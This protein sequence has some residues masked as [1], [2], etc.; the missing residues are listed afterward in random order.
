MAHTHPSRLNMNITYGNNTMTHPPNSP[1]LSLTAPAH[2]PKNQ[3]NTP[4]NPKYTHRLLIT[5]TK[6]YLAATARQILD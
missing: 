3:P 4:P 2:N 5:S 1:Q 6:P